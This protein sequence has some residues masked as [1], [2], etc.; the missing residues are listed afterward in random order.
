MESTQVWEDIA[1]KNTDTCPKCCS[2]THVRKKTVLIGRASPKALF[3][4]ERAGYKRKDQLAVDEC[5][6]EKISDAPLEQFVEG[7]YC[8]VCDL[9]FV[10]DEIRAK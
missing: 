4:E 2:N 8:S 6:P 9:G 5:N 10:S 7:Y 3:L 1:M